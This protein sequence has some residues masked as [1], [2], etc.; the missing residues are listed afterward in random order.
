MSIP[1]FQKVFLP[2]LRAIKDG[3]E[4]TLQGLYDVLSG[5]FQLTD[6]ERATRLPSGN[7]E[8][9]TN[10][11]GWARTYLKKAGLLDSP[12]RGVFMITE[13]G[14]ELLQENLAELKVRDLKRFPDFLEFHRG[15]E[16]NGEEEGQPLTDL[17]PEETFEK[18]FQQYEEILAQELLVK[19][20]GCL[21][22]FFEQLVVDLLVKMGY[23]G[24]RSDAGQAVGRSGDEGI[25]GI[26]KEDHLGLDVI[27]LQAKRW[28]NPVGRGEIQKFAG[29]LQGQ[30]AKKGIFITTST[31]QSS[32]EEYAAKIESKIILIDGARLASLMIK[33]GVGVALK[34]AYELKK[35]DADYFSEE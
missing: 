19:V 20:K 5:E 33:H 16:K 10:R 29:A 15:T 34:T 11:V 26:I 13:R 14:K 28:D 30:R 22:K 6:V 12:R 24:S 4:H 21:P 23:G 2:F 17:T 3:K 35:L 9:F 7:Q 31:F 8:V 1:D 18:G 32:A 27:Y 25:D